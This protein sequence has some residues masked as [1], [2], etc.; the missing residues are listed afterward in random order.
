MRV[1]KEV[2]MKQSKNFFLLLLLF[3]IVILTVFFT[4]REIKLIGRTPTGNKDIF[5]ID[6]NCK[7]SD[8]FSE[9]DF[10]VNDK[11]ISW[12]Q[13]SLLRIF[14][15]PAYEFK[16]IIAPGSSNAYAFTVNN[17]NKFKINYA[18]TFQEKN[19]HHINMKYRLKKNNKYLTK[20]YVTYENL[21]LADLKLEALTHDDYILEWKWFDA[22]N[23][24]EVSFVEASYELKITLKAESDL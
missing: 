13:N 11:E 24:T 1:K 5:N 6:C 10:F 18:F 12:Q 2:N 15:N 9:N 16:S 21:N 19:D 7:E 17:N 4:I 3:I 20:G 23:D 14:S 22:Q 8:V